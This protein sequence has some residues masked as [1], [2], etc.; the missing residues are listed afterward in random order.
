MAVFGSILTKRL[1]TPPSPSNFKDNLFINFVK[2]KISELSHF[3]ELPPR[4]LSVCGYK[5]LTL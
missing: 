2:K 1:K 5:A 3:F 4:R